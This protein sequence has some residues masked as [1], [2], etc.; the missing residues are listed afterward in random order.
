M[1]IDHYAK[2]GRRDFLP[3]CIVFFYQILPESTKICNSSA[4]HLD[5][6]FLGTI[7]GVIV[8]CQS[9]QEHP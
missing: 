1:I 3:R 5:K 2:D 9:T 6:K 7:F 8:C 4:M